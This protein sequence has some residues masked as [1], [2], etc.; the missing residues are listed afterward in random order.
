[1]LKMKLTHCNIDLGLRE[2]QTCESAS[3]CSCRPVWCSSSRA[4][5]SAVGVSQHSTACGT[6]CCS[7]AWAKNAVTWLAELQ[8]LGRALECRLAKLSSTVHWVGAD[9]RPSAL[10]CCC[11]RTCAR[12]Q[13]L[14]DSIVCKVRYGLRHPRHAVALFL[15]SLQSSCNRLELLQV[16]GFFS[17]EQVVLWLGHQSCK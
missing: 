2:Q 8:A 17:C 10:C 12:L 15:C 11:V 16:H 5:D 14:L 7:A 13:A 9:T 4:A 3:V 1:M 6:T